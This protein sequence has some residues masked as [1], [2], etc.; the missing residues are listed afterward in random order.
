MRGIKS[1]TRGHRGA[2]FPA[3]I[4]T[5]A[6]GVIPVLA[7]SSS[8]AVW[9]VKPDGSGDVATIA[10]AVAA[11][12]SGDTIFLADGTF[13]G[14]G[15]RDVQV[16]NKSLIICSQS[17]NPLLCIID[18]GGS[19]SEPHRALDFRVDSPK[20][21]VLAGVTIRGGYGSSAGGVY[22]AN[23]MAEGGTVTIVDCVFTED[24]CQWSGGAITAVNDCELNLAGCQFTS[25]TAD[26]GAALGLCAGSTTIAT[27]CTF[28]DNTATHGGAVYLSCAGEGAYATFVG[29]TFSGNTATLYGGAFYAASGTPIL[30]GCRFEGNSAD[31]NGGALYLEGGLSMTGC[32]CVRNTTEGYGSSIYCVQPQP[33]T[34]TGCSFVADSSGTYVIY[35]PPNAAPVLGQTVIAFAKNESAIACGAPAG[36]LVLTCCDIFGNEYGDWMGCIAGQASVNGNISLDPLFCD[37]PTGDVSVESCSP[38]L[39]ANNTCSLNIGAEGQGCLCGEATVPTTWGSIKSLY[40]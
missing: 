29:C 17:G 19:S 25:N 33:I 1:A 36:A 7:G 39:A 13:S 11:A 22:V 24:E 35:F 28:T 4:L 37:I 6:L 20:E 26:M 34:I 23:S 10:A 21:A 18:C 8:A 30:M 40:K 27:G 16:P 31:G 3:L 38:C 12:A 9:H 5:I 14:N 32:V 15:N 2:R